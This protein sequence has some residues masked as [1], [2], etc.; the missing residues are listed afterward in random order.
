MHKLVSSCIDILAP[1]AEANKISVT[2]LMTPQTPRI[3]GE[4]HAIKQ[5][6]VNLLS[7]AIKFTPDGGRVQISA[8]VDHEG[9]LLLSITDTGIGL[10]DEEIEVALS[11]F[12]QVNSS[13]SK[14]EAGTGLG[15][16]LVR[17]LM[18]LHGG[19]FELFSQKGIGTTATLVF[20]AKRVS[21]H[22]S[23]QTV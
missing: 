15:L 8:D 22:T 14:A 13:L 3:V 16:T 19:T 21:Y 12:G 4:S 6:V 9:Q 10:T 2:S 1:K 11:P 5:M 7:N 23:K 20:P 17:A 18:D